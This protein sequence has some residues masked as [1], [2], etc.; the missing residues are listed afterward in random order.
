MFKLCDE[1][2]MQNKDDMSNLYESLAGN[3]AGVV[4]YNKDNRHDTV[5]PELKVTIDSVCDIMLNKSQGSEIMR[6]AAV[7]SLILK[8]TNE[9]CLDFKYDKM[10]Q[11]LRSTSWDSEMAE[12]G[13]QW[14]YQTCSEFGFFQTSALNSTQKMFGNAF[15]EE[16]FV[17]QCNDIFGKHFDID[18][19]KKGIERT[20]IIYGGMDNHADNV[21][22]VHGSVDPW[23]V[24]GITST[25]RKGAPAI[26]IKGNFL[27]LNKHTFNFS[28]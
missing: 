12:G 10:I 6:L 8:K 3:F 15:P 18:L 20:N 26:F 14:T 16:F 22:Y 24:L 23:H 19:L 4:Q 17:K 7:N 13:R 27:A 1:M 2:E 9:T 28:I 5:S 11:K 25:L 21:V